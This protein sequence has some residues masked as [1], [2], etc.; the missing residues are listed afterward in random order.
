MIKN[1]IFQHF[2]IETLNKKMFLLINATPASNKICI[3]T[4]IF[5]AKYL[6]LITIIFIIFL[7]HK[8]FKN[9]SFIIKILFSIF[10]STIFYFIL[11]KAFPYPRPFDMSF[12]YHFITHVSNNSYPSKHS[13]VV[14]TFAF[15]FFF[16][17]YWFFVILLIISISISL[18]RI[19]LG[20][21]WPL[22]ILSSMLASLLSCI[23]SQK[24]YTIL[25]KIL[26]K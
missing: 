23:C 5:L 7:I 25:N 10:Y 14:F 18:S 9:F 8:N 11:S 2:N 6:I 13:I 12:G 4:A 1:N 24:T 21:H 26:F 19:Y 20:L 16:C 15:S 17:N 22:D 3:I